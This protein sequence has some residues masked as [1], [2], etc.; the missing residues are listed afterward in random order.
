MDDS[1]QTTTQTPEEKA[2]KVYELSRIKREEPE[3]YDEMVKMAA[4]ARL[5]GAS[6]KESAKIS[7]IPKATLMNW[8]RH[9]DSQGGKRW[10][11]AL[12]EV[13]EL[14]QVQKMATKTDQVVDVS[15]YT[16]PEAACEAYSMQMAARLISTATD[17]DVADRLAMEAAK[18]GL[19]LAGHSPIAKS[20]VVSAPLDDPRVAELLQGTL[21]EMKQLRQQSQVLL[22]DY[23]GEALEAST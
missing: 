23:T 4:H 20:V 7:G 18:H 2:K 15:P 17:P 13:G 14:L 8:S 9:Q 22:A 12:K 1:P 5:K 3:R 6:L 11:E 19:A 21:A 10:R 16:T